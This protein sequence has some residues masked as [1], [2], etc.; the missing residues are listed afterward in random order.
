MWL[1][2]HAPERLSKLVLCNTRASVDPEVWTNRIANV[3]KSGLKGIAPEIV[4]RWFTPRF[5]Q[6]SPAT[7]L[8]AQKMVEEAAEEGYIATCE[9]IRDMD[10]GS[11]LSR[12]DMPTLVI[13]GSQDMAATPE[14]GRFIAGQIPSAR[15]AELDTSHISNIE[16]PSRFIAEVTRFLVT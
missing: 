6:T 2:S 12:I 9:G 7:V 11:Q 8:A 10:L 1:G 15:Y 4:E 3:R 13:S 14:D 16:D 5:R